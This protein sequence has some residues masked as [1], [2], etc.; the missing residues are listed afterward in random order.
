MVNVANLIKEEFCS[1]GRLMMCDND[2]PL[3][4]RDAALGDIYKKMMTRFLNRKDDTIAL[5]KATNSLLC[6]QSGPGGGKSRFMDEVAKFEDVED[7]IGS[8]K[9]FNFSK[10]F[11][12]LTEDDWS[13]CLQR[14]KNQLSIC[15]TLNSAMAIDSEDLVASK[16]IVYRILFSY[17]YGNKATS[18]R[19]FTQKFRLNSYDLA[20]CLRDIAS[21]H[22]EI[23]GI[24]G[25]VDIFLGVDEVMKWKKGA[26]KRESFDE[27]RSDLCALLNRTNGNELGTVTLL[28]SSL[29]PNE[30]E[31]ETS[32]SGRP[33][34]FTPIRLLS[35]E[36]VETLLERNSPLENTK[37]E[38]FLFLQ[39]L[40]DSSGHPR[41]VTNLYTL[42]QN[43]KNLTMDFEEI[44]TI[45]WRT[46]GAKNQDTLIPLV[47]AALLRKK[48]S[49]FKKTYTFGG[50]LFTDLMMEGCVMNTTGIDFNYVPIVR[51]SILMSVALEDSLPFKS[52]L[53]LMNFDH[54]GLNMSTA[55]EMFHAYWEAT[56]RTFFLQESSLNATFKDLYGNVFYSNEVLKTQK[57]GV[58]EEL[59][60][61]KVVA[62]QLASSY[63]ENG[64]MK[65]IFTFPDSNNAGFDTMIF[66]GE[67]FIF[68][69]NKWS[70]TDAKTVIGIGEIEAKL[71]KCASFIKEINKNG[72]I[73]QKAKCVFVLASCRK[74]TDVLEGQIAT[75]LG[76]KNIIFFGRQ[77]ITMEDCAYGPSL[78]LRAIFS[79]EVSK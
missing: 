38:R 32:A 58:C 48:V 18:F 79:S 12:K 5:K 61:V 72:E 53:C 8:S 50:K 2:F 52:L 64:I 21:H 77:H 16:S 6:I 14:V 23:N 1:N 41:M 57:I 9:D 76:N 15:I 19:E 28:I 39:L 54:P 68:I 78:S 37:R 42:L 56:M 27:F 17:L 43:C 66:N 70:G 59:L 49:S 75:R 34:L 13:E 46:D 25:P 69:E 55:Y 63:F 47:S 71:S 26:S 60:S 74:C 30:I 31:N 62:G 36:A 33:V 3:Q 65:G 73:I 10:R 40:A 11:P 22:K 67:H 51:P 35:K 4:E 44:R 7:L 24:Q 20:S 29:N 45:M